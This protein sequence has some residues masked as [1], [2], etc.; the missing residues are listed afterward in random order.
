MPST[1]TDREYR[2]ELRSL[3]DSL[4]EMAG[5]VEQMIAQATDAWMRQDCDLARRTIA[6]DRRVNR[7]EVTIDELCL[8]IL[9]KRQ[10]L[11]SDL[12]FITI[13]LK[14]VTDL[15]RIGDLAVNVCER[16]IGLVDAQGPRVVHEGV[17]QMA[18]IVQAMVRDA[19]DAFVAGDA[20]AAM[21]VIERDNEV[22]DLYQRAFGELIDRMVEDRVLVNSAVSLQSAAKYLERIGDH[23]V[24]LAELV[25]FM[26]RGKDIRHLGQRTNSETSAVIAARDVSSAR[27]PQAS[28][29]S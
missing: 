9:A 19:I 28:D 25:V 4:L 22:D 7:A 16:A 24:N 15:E 3:R 11:A 17:A 2:E 26:V 6:E 18:T 20:Q 23:A 29:G 21:E 1:H 27:N 8:L 14:M 13:A 10:P 5:F 12:R